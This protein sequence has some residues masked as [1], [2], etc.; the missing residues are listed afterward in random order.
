MKMYGLIEGKLK[1]SLPW[2]EV[3]SLVDVLGS[4][5]SGKQPPVTMY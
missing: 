4:L 3:V 5:P 2:Q 1:H